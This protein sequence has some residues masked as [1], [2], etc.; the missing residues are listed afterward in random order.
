MALAPGRARQLIDDLLVDSGISLTFSDAVM[1]EVR[2]HQ[3]DPQIDDPALEDMTGLPFVTIDNHDSRDLD[4]ALQLEARS[5]GGFVLRYALADGSFYVRPGTALWDEALR[6]GSSYYVPARC[7][8]MLPAELSEDLVSLN[9]GV[10]RRA[11]VFEWQLAAD[12]RRESV[13][14]CRARIHSRAGLA[15]PDVQALHDDPAASPLSGQPYTDS[16]MILGTVG[17]LLMEEAFERGVVP[18]ERTELG[19]RYDDPVRQ[20][21]LVACANPRH[22]I[23]Q[24]NAELSLLCNRDGATLLHAAATDPQVQPVFRVHDPPPDD[25]LES[26][27]AIIDAIADAHGLEDPRWRWDRQGQRLAEFV[28]G[29]PAEPA[30]V[31]AAI[32]RQTL[33]VNVRS[34]FRAEHG[35]HYALRLD[36]YARFSSP[37]REMAGIF[38]HKEALERLGVEAPSASPA[39][40]EA[41]REAVVLAAN[42]SKEVQKKLVKA[43]H[44]LALDALLE[45]PA[46]ELAGTVLGTRPTRLYVTLDSPP[47]EVKV[48]LPDVSEVMGSRCRVAR[49]GAS[50]RSDDG[51]LSLRVGDH[52]R[53]R[54]LGRN[55]RGYWR[56][57]PEVA[58]G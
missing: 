22:R 49:D 30:G 24:W 1:A 40:D 3:A 46:T 47:M 23:E 15:Y 32:E 14:L 57:V 19:V 28:D 2:T 51:R 54:C 29:L 56:L 43:V 42:R 45:D 38:T 17:E 34:E 12:G 41:M 36:A 25:R 55:R 44:R 21:R 11:L 37:M 31:R 39:V 4:Q 20:E 16:L 10:D 35:G 8:A 26:L 6:R 18:R 27:V 7:V 33:M 48:Y 50:V 9:P 58:E 52:V 53:L 13:R 5:G